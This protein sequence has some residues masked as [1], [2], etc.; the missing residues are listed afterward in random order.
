[1]AA[2][3][4][5][6]ALV[7]VGVVAATSAAVAPPARATSACSATMSMA[8]PR[9]NQTEVLTVRTTRSAK[10]SA[11]VHYKTSKPVKSGTASTTGVATIKFDISRATYGY[12]VVVDVTT[13]SHQ[14]CATS[15]TPET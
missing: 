3:R 9:D 14:S 11:T 6:A 1:M 13:S 4:V 8:H 5:L 7:T 2:G 10:T 15:F 12:R